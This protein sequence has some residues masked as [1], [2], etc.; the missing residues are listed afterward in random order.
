VNLLAV[1]AGVPVALT[2]A[3]CFG[4]SAVL[5]FRVTHEVPPTPA[6]RPVLLLELVRHR[7]WRWSIALAA[8][9]F[10]LQV[11][12]LRLAPLILVQPLLVTGVLWY[13]LLT[14]FVY[15]RSP[16]GVVLCGV[17][18]CLI[19]LTAFL[20]VAQPS[21]GG[22]GGLD[23]LSSALPLAIGL[24]GAVA[25]CLGVASRVDPQWGAI[26]LSIAAGICYGVTAGL[27]RSLAPF[28]EDGVVAVFGHW[29]AYAICVLGPVGVLLNQN[30]YQVGRIGAV[31]LVIITVTDPLV[32][33]GV[34][35]LWLDETI[36]T[37]V[38]AVIGEVIAL[39][40][41][42]VGV[43]LVALR[44][45]HVAQWLPPDRRTRPATHAGH[46]EGTT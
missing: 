42:V 29:Q 18:L 36:Q 33:I 3:A 22:G 10:G 35:I 37:G 19:S 46:V 31:T 9:G 4:S 38:A 34:G 43:L 44:A 11:L 20:V 8:A 27:V 41:L 5:Q 23:R 39:A 26:P 25:V 30:S 15:R 1:A 24:A 17:V 16:D 21:Q 12:A 40:G 45:P 14:A 28:F 6:G 7:A 2:S 32:S 13:S